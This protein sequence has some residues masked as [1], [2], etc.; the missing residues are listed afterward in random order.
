MS[1]HMESII[2]LLPV[3]I[4]WVGLEE[5]FVLLVG[6]FRRQCGA[7][8]EDAPEPVALANQ[9]SDL[10]LKIGDLQSELTGLRAVEIRLGREVGAE[11]D[12]TDN[13]VRDHGCHDDFLSVVTWP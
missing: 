2:F 5:D 12:L 4:F 1:V 13:Q 10:G 9:L 7:F 11:A 8:L 6:D 3:K